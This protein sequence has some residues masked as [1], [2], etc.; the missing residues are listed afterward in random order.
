[1]RSAECGVRSAECGVRSAECGVRSAECG[2]RSAESRVQM[3][4]STRDF[5][6]LGR[7][8]LR[9]QKGKEQFSFDHVSKM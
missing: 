1:M 2:V 5:H 6:T 3:V 8:L 4:Y 7:S 9:K